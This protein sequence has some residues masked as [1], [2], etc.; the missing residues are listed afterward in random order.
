[1]SEL[2]IKSEKELDMLY[3]VGIKGDT[4]Y[5]GEREII[6]EVGY[7]LST[8][9]V[10]VDKMD[11]DTF[12]KDLTSETLR[13]EDTWVKDIMAGLKITEEKVS[14]SIKNAILDKHPNWEYVKLDNRYVVIKDKNDKQNLGSNIARKKTDNYVWKFNYHGVLDL[15]RM[16]LNK[17]SDSDKIKK[18]E[19]ENE[20]P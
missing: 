6:K 15:N 2:K 19:F 20:T 5:L 17:Y 16:T 4:Y 1:M 8:M 7:D 12:F 18:V 9:N 10:V 14:E 11:K 3:D 13:V